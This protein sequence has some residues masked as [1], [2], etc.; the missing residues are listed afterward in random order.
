MDTADVS[1][2][3]VTPFHLGSPAPG[4]LR[5]PGEVVPRDFQLLGIFHTF[6]VGVLKS[7]IV[8]FE[9]SHGP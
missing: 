3:A 7:I 2:P 1:G 9:K 6:V 8:F 5:G 4:N